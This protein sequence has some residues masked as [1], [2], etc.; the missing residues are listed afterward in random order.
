MGLKSVAFD[1]GAEHIIS[2][3]LPVSD[4]R[5]HMPASVLE[6]KRYERRTKEKQLAAAV[7]SADAHVFDPGFPDSW[8]RISPD[9]AIGA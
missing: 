3:A 4:V 6:F 2:R 1:C 8:P 5:R 9:I 7:L